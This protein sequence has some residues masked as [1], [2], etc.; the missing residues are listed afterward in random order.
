MTI[1]RSKYEWAIELLRQQLETISDRRKEAQEDLKKA[2]DMFG[3]AN[4]KLEL[5]AEQTT[6]I[7]AAILAL[8]A[9]EKRETFGHPHRDAEW[10]P[11]HKVETTVRQDLDGGP[12][13]GLLSVPYEVTYCAECGAGDPKTEKPHGKKTDPCVMAKP[14][15]SVVTVARSSDAGYIVDEFGPVQPR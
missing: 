3:T 5:V 6:E 7:N 15:V 10:H 14:C 2:A 4:R 8:R 12:T 13:T 9:V 1:Q 11:S